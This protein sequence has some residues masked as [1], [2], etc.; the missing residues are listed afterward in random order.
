MPSPLQYLNFGHTSPWNPSSM[1]HPLQHFLR[2]Y[3]TPFHPCYFPGAFSLEVSSFSPFTRPSLQYLFSHRLHPYTVLL[4]SYSP[5]DYLPSLPFHHPWHSYSPFLPR[6]L[7]LFP[8]FTLLPFTFVLSPFLPR[9]PSSSKVR[10]ALP[11][12]RSV[13]MTILATHPPDGS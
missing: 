5:L 10:I 7:S 11:D 12:R 13:A 1:T 6:N 8:F 3:P 4:Y 9:E 2:I